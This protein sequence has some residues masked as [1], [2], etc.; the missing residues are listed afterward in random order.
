MTAEIHLRDLS[1]VG[2]VPFER[3]A[4]ESQFLRL[5]FCDIE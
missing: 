5:S 1:D 4:T 2:G 3:E